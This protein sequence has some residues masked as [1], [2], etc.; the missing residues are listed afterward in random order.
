M[1]STYVGRLRLIGLIEGFSFLALVFV[2][3]P[4]KYMFGDPTWVKAVGQVHGLLWV[5]FCFAL[6]DAKS[7]QGWSFK[8]ALV[9]FIASMLPFGPFVVDKRIKEGRI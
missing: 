5:V 8:Q 6:V 3:M 4:K 9:S 7:N 1:L 2:A